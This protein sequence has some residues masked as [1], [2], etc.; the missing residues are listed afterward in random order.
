[1]RTPMN[2]CRTVTVMV[3][4]KVSPSPSDIVRDEIS[5]VTRTTRVANGP[6]HESS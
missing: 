2:C 6:E 1:M 4:P 3:K 5:T